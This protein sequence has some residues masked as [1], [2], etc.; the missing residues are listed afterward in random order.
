V[1]DKMGCSCQCQVAAGDGLNTGASGCFQQNAHVIVSTSDLSL[2]VCH[3]LQGLKAGQFRP[4][5]CQAATQQQ[6][7][8]MTSFIIKA[9]EGR[10]APK[11][12]QSDPHCAFCRILRGEGPAY[13]VFENE[14]VIAILGMCFCL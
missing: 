7:N 10:V 14:H 3:G 11:S 13:K 2:S 6:R 8:N 9:H 5:Q 4:G 12:W 1:D